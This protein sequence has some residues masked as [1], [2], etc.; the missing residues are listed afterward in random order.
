MPAEV[1]LPTSNGGRV[2]IPIYVAVQPQWYDPNPPDPGPWDKI[3]QIATIT[4]LVS[5]I[6]D[7]A[8]GAE[9]Q[10]VATRALKQAVADFSADAELKQFEHSKSR[11]T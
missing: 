4:E 2:C 10:Q 1:C 6:A 8:I 11:A 7:Q 9:L 5:R 3:V